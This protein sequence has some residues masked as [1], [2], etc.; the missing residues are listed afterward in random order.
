MQ[1][2]VNY[3]L[4]CLDYTVNLSKI[5]EKATL[6]LTDLDQ[7]QSVESLIEEWKEGKE[8]SDTFF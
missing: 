4:I 7:C 8:Y 3:L 5:P 1:W 2:I 6:I